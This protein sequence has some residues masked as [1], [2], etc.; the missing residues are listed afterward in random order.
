MIALKSGLL[1]RARRSFKT[2]KLVKVK[3]KKRA[4]R[5]MMGGRKRK[6]ENV[7]AVIEGERRINAGA[8]RRL[9]KKWR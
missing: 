5:T 9:P 6:R 1:N 3:R 2:S 8:K 4:T 7:N